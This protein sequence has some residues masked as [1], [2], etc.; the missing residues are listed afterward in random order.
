[1][2]INLN[3]ITLDLMIHISNVEIVNF[4]RIVLKTYLKVYFNNLSYS[5]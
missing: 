5:R 4:N 2:T 3:A 1:M